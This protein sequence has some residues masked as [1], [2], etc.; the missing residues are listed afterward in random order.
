[1]KALVISDSHGNISNLKHV[2]GFGQSI[3]VDAVIHCGDWN[4]VEA[5]DTVLSFRIPV[6]TVLGNAD[7][8][9]EVVEKL[10]AKSEKFSE[11]F[12]QFELDGRKIG[13]VHRFTKDV[14]SNIGSLDIIF[15]GHFHSKDDR[16]INGVRVV[17][18]GAII[19]G[20]NFAVYETETNDVQF[21]KDEN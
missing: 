15:A 13:V 2:L 8:R 1:M 11:D 7:V 6:Y 16:I 4:T 14:I 17:R 20:I 10:K 12:L 19:N 3:K 9:E 18:P 5:V 21:V